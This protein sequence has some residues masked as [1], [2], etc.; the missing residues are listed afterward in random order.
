MAVGVLAVVLTKGLI[1]LLIISISAGAFCFACGACWDLG[2]ISGNHV[3]GHVICFKGCAGQAPGPNTRKGVFVLVV[4]GTS[5]F[6]G[7]LH[8]VGPVASLG[9]LYLAV[10]DLGTLVA[11]HRTACSGGV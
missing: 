1:E 3:V 5:E 10:L 2:V 6:G 9:V 8:K 11:T 7:L 4:I